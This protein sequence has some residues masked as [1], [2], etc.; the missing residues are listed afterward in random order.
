MAI[1][2]K[3]PNSTN[4]GVIRI[5]NRISHATKIIW[6]KLKK[7]LITKVKDYTKEY[8]HGFRK[9][10]KTRDAIAVMKILGQ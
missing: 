4:C 5:I 3:K 7:I 2:K 1:I 10:C 9:G 8:Q 6:S